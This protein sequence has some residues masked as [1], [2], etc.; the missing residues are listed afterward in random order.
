MDPHH[1]SQGSIEPKLK[2][3]PL[4]VHK[5]HSLAKTE[6]CGNRVCAQDLRLNLGSLRT[7]A[8]EPR[9]HHEKSGDQDR[10]QDHQSAFADY[11]TIPAER[12]GNNPRLGFRSAKLRPVVA[13]ARNYPSGP[14]VH[15]GVWCNRLATG[16]AETP[17]DGSARPSVPRCS[18]RAPLPLAPIRARALQLHP[19]TRGS[20]GPTT[21][22][23]R[24]PR[25]LP[26][27]RPASF[28]PSGQIVPARTEPRLEKSE[29]SLRPRLRP[30]WEPWGERRCQARKACSSRQDPEFDPT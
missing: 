22:R 13:R 19:Q 8:N 9:N 24:Q 29:P 15:A 23:S 26:L 3:L 4:Q 27:R 28:A 25:S 30:D 7:P 11:W 21:A 6:R 5:T 20:T 18:L 2:F 12:I 1:A 16:Q 14:R 17:R 10:Q